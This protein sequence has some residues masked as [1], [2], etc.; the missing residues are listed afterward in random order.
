MRNEA[1]PG[2][3]FA[4]EQQQQAQ[5]DHQVRHEKKGRLPSTGRPSSP[6]PSGLSP[7]ERSHPTTK[8][9][10]FAF[11]ALCEAAIRPLPQHL[12]ARR[13]PPA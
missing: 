7:R 12:T 9:A 5:H 13:S 4:E 10:S 6:T 1:A 11:C 3:A 8:A 2:R